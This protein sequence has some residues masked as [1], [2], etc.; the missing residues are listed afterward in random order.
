LAG[1]PRRIGKWHERR[2]KHLLAG[3][4]HP[5]GNSLHWNPEM[6]HS[7]QLLILLITLFSISLGSAAWADEPIATTQP[8]S[9]LPDKWKY[10]LFNLTPAGQLRGMDT[11]RPNITNTP[12]T[13]DAGHLQ[14]ETGAIDY[15]YFRDHSS[16]NNVRENDFD[17]GQFNLRLGVLNNLEIN[18]VVDAFDSVQIHDYAAGTASHA[19]SFG[20][21]VFGAKMNLWGN[22][23]GDEIWATALAIQPQFKFPTAQNDVGNGRFEFSITAPFLLNLPA[24]FHLGIQPGVSY[25]R[26]GSDTGYVTGFP[27]SVSL[28]R[29]VIGN[30][31]VYLEYA[32]DLTTERHVETEQTIDVGGTY[33]LNDHIVLDAGVNFG[34]NKASNN[35]EVLVG[36]SVRF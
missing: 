33:P 21:T 9:Q 15:S 13:I 34:L 36:I 30:L 35:V 17:F 24:G 3:C 27:T 11:D 19:G 12:H 6:K 10:T 7:S 32:C 2:R 26:N 5:I 28:D 20:D 4:F 25:E 18:A 14:I 23:G 29:V 1:H 31:D 8:T 16:N 22:D